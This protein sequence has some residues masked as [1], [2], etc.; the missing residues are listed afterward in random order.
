MKIVIALA[1]EIE[2]QSAVSRIQTQADFLSYFAKQFKG[3]TDGTSFKFPKKDAYLIPNKNKIEL[4]VNKRKVADFDFPASGML[5]HGFDL[6]TMEASKAALK[7]LKTASALADPRVQPAQAPTPVPRAPRSVEMADIAEAVQKA[8]QAPVDLDTSAPKTSPLKNA[9]TEALCVRIAKL[10]AAGKSAEAKVKLNEFIAKAKPAPARWE[11]IAMRERI[12]DLASQLK[13]PKEKPVTNSTE[14]A[15]A[16]PLKKRTLESAANTIAQFYID[17]KKSLATRRLNALILS[18]DVST[19]MQKR[20]N[21]RIEY[22]VKTLGKAPSAKPTVK[23]T[24]TPSVK[25]TPVSAPK[26]GV[27]PKV[28]RGLVKYEPLDPPKVTRTT[29][30]TVAESLAL[31]SQ[32]TILRKLKTRCLKFGRAL[33]GKDAGEGYLMF[34][35][36]DYSKTN[37]SFTTPLGKITKNQIFSMMAGIDADVPTGNKK[38]NTQKG[39]ATC[40]VCGAQLGD[41]DMV[42]KLTYPSGAI[43]HYKSHGIKPALIH[44]NVMDKTTGKLFSVLYI[45]KDSEVPTQVK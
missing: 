40:R 26:D 12:A 27:T 23:P 32:T 31:S 3:K 5:G 8:S 44:K 34:W 18:E 20:L 4:K 33:S 2:S 25:P 45:G 7:Y 37:T 38:G 43:P 22:L 1:N 10:V 21:A 36:F 39:L 41:S 35:P 14:D 6:V 24:A 19:V 15:A 17:G 16:Q 30:D 13:N 42:G 29:F 11:V 28:V 9:K